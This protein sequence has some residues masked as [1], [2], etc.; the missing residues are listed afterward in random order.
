M[1]TYL[2]SLGLWN[3]FGSIVMLGLIN[4]NFGHNM[5]VKWTKIFKEDY[6]LNNYGR[7]WCAWAAGI[8]IFFGAV[9]V[10]AWKWQFEPLGKFLIYT[11]LLAYSIFT[12]L[13][14][15]GLIQKSVGS[16]IYSVLV[17]F[18]G[19]IVWGVWVLMNLGAN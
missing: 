17:I 8:N 5:F 6:K 11:D 9:N 4:D 12:I 3:F 1:Y 16:G 14:V 7:I 19:W 2:L 13:A 15:R 18:L 10:M